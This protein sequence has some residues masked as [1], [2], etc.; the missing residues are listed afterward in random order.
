[1]CIGNARMRGI[2]IG[3]GKVEFVVVLLAGRLA[4]QRAQIVD[5]I[6]D[7]GGAEFAGARSP[8]T[9]GSERRVDGREPRASTLGDYE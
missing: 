1:M 9:Q 4:M 3:D 5:V 6:A 8:G 2:G 7:A